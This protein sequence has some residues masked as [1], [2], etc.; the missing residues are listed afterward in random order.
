MNKIYRLVW[1]RKQSALVVASEFAK[2][3]STRRTCTA[4][5]PEC[6]LLAAALVMGPLGSAVAGSLD[7]GKATGTGIAIGAGSTATS[8]GDKLGSNAIAIG[9]GAT[10]NNSNGSLAIGSATASADGAISIGLTGTF[11]GKST[12]SGEDS[13]AIGNGANATAQAATALGVTA[14]AAASFATAVGSGA[15]ASGASSS[16]VGRDSRAASTDSVAIGRQATA[17]SASGGTGAVAVGSTASAVGAN[18]SAFGFGSAAAG[19][20]ALAAG[21]AAT[22]SASDAVALGRAASAGQNGAVALGA[23]SVSAAAVATSS[24]T[25]AGT[26][27]AFAGTAPASTVSIGAAGAERTLTNVAAGRL[28]QSSTD[29]VNGSQLNATNQEVTALDGRVDT[30]GANTV[31]SLGGGASYNA[32]TGQLTA[33]TY[34]VDG[35][36]YRNVGD[37]L[38]N[39]DGRTTNNTTAITNLGNQINNGTVGLVQQDATSK[40]ITVAK[41]KDGKK[42]DFAGS[43]GNRVLTGVDKG[44]VSASSVEGVNGAQLYGTNKSVVDSLGG[45]AKLNPDGTIAGPTYTVDGKPVKNVGDAITNIDGRTTTNSTAITNVDKRVTNLGDQLNSGSVGLVQQNTT[46]RDITVAKDTNGSR[47]N[48]TGTAGTRVLA[49]VSKGAISTTS[50]EAV[51]GSQL[52]GSSK[53]VADALGG[54]SKVNPDGTVSAPTYTVDGKPVKNVGDAITNIDGRVTKNS[55]SITNVDNRVTNLGDQIEDGAVGLVKQ[56]VLSGNI[57]VAEDR[58]GKQVSFAGTDGDRVLTGVAK[59]AV[60]ATSAE[61]VNG[62]QLHG[63][64]K[65]VADALGGGSKVNPD[66]TVS[67]P[68]YTVDGKPVKNVGDAITNIDGRTTTN[69]TAITNV[70]KRVTNLGDQL[71]SGSVGLVQQDATSRNITV[72]KDADGKQVS[73][74]GTEGARVL[75]G[76]AKGAVSA[77]S[78]EAINGS[79]L[80]GTNQSVADG[81]GGGT[82]LNPDGTISG[83]T[84]TVDGKPVKN[85]GDAITNIDGRTTTNTTA[86]TNLGN[87]LSSG[88]VGLVQQDATSRNITVAKDA[89]GKQVSLAGTEG[90]R[91][92]TGLAKG[93]V[94]A[95]S[96]EAINSSQLHGTNQSVADGLGGGTK[97]NPDGTISGP[98]YTV[99]G[100][101]VKNV[102]DAITNIDGRTTNNTTAI[103]NL[104]DQLNSGSVGLVQQEA[105]SRNITVAK[106]K[107]GKQVS[108]TGIDGDRALTGV[109]KGAITASSAEAV[110]GSQLH[111]SS[112]SV[113]DAL[114]GGSKVNPDGTISAPTY[115]VD[116][117]PVKNVGDA[118]TNIDGRTTTNSTAITNV[119]KRVTNLGDQLN[120]GSIGL[121]QQDATT[122]DII[123][124]KDTNGSRVNFSG[125]G[126]A[127]VLVGVAK[128]A[129]SAASTEAV[130]GAQLHATNQSLVESLGGGAKVN[131]DGTISGPT[132]TVNGKPVNNAGDAITNIDGR[133]TNNTTAITNLG[134]QINSGTVGLVQ[135]DAA[136]RN[137][138]VAKDKDGKQVSV[139]GTEGERVVT[140]VAKGAVSNGSTEAINGAQLRATNQSIA[141]GLGGGAKVNP[142]GS[143]SGPT[144]KVGG[145]TVNNAGDAITNIDSRVT[146]NTQAIQQITEGGSVKYFR[147]NATGEAALASG[148]NAVAAGPAAVAADAG[149]V[150][151][152]NGAQAK[153]D[154][155]VAIGAGAVA[156]RANTVSVGRAGQERTIS[157]VAAGTAETDAA[158]V[159]Q[160]RALQAGSAQYDK[161]P[162]GGA[163][164]MTNMTLGGPAGRGTTVHNVANG[165]APMDAVNVRQ[166]Q[167]GMDQAVGQSRAYTDARVEA[168]GNDMWNVQRESRAG[169][170]S[171][172]AMAGLVQAYEAGD[173]LMSVGMGSFQGEY[174]LA[175]G[176]SGV[177]DNGKYLYKAQA[178]SN[179]RKDFGFSV[180]AGWRW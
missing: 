42:V 145:K 123:V 32:A 107:D 65:S 10:A 153:A 159:G 143:I 90:A 69:S 12:A 155:S 29:A 53:S 19:A 171:A 1:S 170:A 51:N 4:V 113:A 77:A 86:I 139:A 40:N 151:V 146:N 125:T 68:T 35:Q 169:T 57:T 81:L 78:T 33:P 165:V 102:G 115:T 62:S 100:K 54:G 71:S 176:L 94:S 163:P 142:D 149:S 177:T 18:A 131:P 52:Y 85:V 124:A 47:V 91:V 59:G 174:S 27:R 60:N 134:N 30:L 14:R 164:D 45:G 154:N 168:L 96:T 88:S 129:V 112:K 24:A 9:N 119:D 89:D 166:L 20:S 178:S 92:L 50:T 136:S 64:S 58:D 76:L 122:R 37:A 38:T 126:G 97:L 98:T 26:S 141:D 6:V 39:I 158:N 73:L 140:G 82:K 137:I 28:S 173:N 44:V 55:T 21:T 93:A 3:D 95:A 116:G 80:H 161:S 172:I 70:D 120:S 152:G 109:A 150:A 111:G 130:N 105:K 104:G 175:M 25:I 157:H 128:G 46:S 132:Y 15:R 84:Y 2:S 133:V 56:D 106:D 117:K 108:F 74:A 31:S 144:Y 5:R 179:T 101:P 87:Q 118:I 167:S 103:T 22:A 49:G 66:G 127:R 156:D 11:D 61:A 99:D 17:G 43:A 121:V 7:G 162:S 135:Q 180:S 23:G 147:A 41:A 16:A 110:N 79:Q 83:P 48:F 114:G 63:S 72:A 36:N 67:A 160:L 138:T 13:M 8:E 148:T 34:Q 75:T